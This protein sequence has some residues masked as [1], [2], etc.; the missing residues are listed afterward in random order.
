M[1]PDPFRV[2]PWTSVREAARLMAQR[3]VGSLV[4]VEDGQVLG[5]VT[6]RDL[7]GAH[8]N[9][10]VVDVLKGPPVAI[11]PEASLLEAKRLMEAE[12]LERLLVVR[13]R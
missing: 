13:D 3:R 8:P 4:V 2:G 12:G 9:R 5:V 11:S 10:L 6:S 1:V 7:R